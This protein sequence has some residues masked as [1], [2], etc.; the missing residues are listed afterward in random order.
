MKELNL[1]CNMLPTERALGMSWFVE[2]DVNIKE[3]PYTR[4][5]IL[6]VVSS[7]YDLFGMA[8]PFVLPSKLP[9]QDLCR[10][11]LG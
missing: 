1:E 2:M 11:G 9:L 8:A 6:S 3:K 5:G 10:K 7:V 4:L